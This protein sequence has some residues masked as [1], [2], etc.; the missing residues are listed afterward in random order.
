MG[1]VVCSAAKR[2]GIAKRIGWHTFWCSLR[3]SYRGSKKSSGMQAV[4]Y[5]RTPPANHGSEARATRKS[6]KIVERSRVIGRRVA[7]LV[8][9]LP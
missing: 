3:R 5:P 1:K 9:A 8:R 2:A 7:Q 4:G 6:V